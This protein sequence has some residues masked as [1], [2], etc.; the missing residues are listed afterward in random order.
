MLK[1]LYRPSFRFQVEEVELEIEKVDG[2][3]EVPLWDPLRTVCSES[4][5]SFTSKPEGKLH[6]CCFSPKWRPEEVEKQIED[7]ETWSKRKKEERNYIPSKPT[8]ER[9]KGEKRETHF[10]SFRPVDRGE[11]RVEGKRPDIT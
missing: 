10:L 7:F 4:M 1:L 8:Q 2:I 6:W 11:A 9:K 3:N 5:L